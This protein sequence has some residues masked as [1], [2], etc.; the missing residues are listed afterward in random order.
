VRAERHRRFYII[1]GSKPS[2]MEKIDGFRNEDGIAV[3][4]KKSRMSKL[5]YPT[6]SS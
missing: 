1:L 2:T 6:R 3:R 4:S 5:S